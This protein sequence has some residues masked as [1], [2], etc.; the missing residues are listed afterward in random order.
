MTL[1]DTNTHLGSVHLTCFC[2]LALF[3]T[4]V[5]QRDNYWYET[6]QNIIN[7]F[8]FGHISDA[9]YLVAHIKYINIIS[10][11]CASLNDRWKY[12]NELPLESKT[13]TTDKNDKFILSWHCDA[14]C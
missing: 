2:K 1:I 6:N 4:G 5:E 12:F 11:I 14:F 7:D 9:F 8:R 3:E 10:F 13:K